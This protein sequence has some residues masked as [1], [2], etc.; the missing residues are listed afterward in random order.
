[1]LALIWGAVR[2]RRA[3]VLTVLI[4]TAPAAALAAAAPWFAEAAADRSTAA[5]VAAAPADQRILSIRQRVV[6]NGDPSAS[7][8]QFTD[9]VGPKLPLPAAAPAVGLVQSL[10][11]AGRSGQQPMPVAYRD[12][13]CAHLRLEGSCPAASLETAISRSTAQQLGLS[14]GQTL[15]L[16]DTLLAEPIKLKVVAIY[17]LAE[18]D[19][20]YW[21]NPFYRAGTGPDPV[22]TPLATFRNRRRPAPSG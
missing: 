22:F 18:P 19:G 4:L 5:D 12:D 11:Q 9:L 15:P 1:M 13:Y 10:D 7:I 16:R 3:Q 21:S 17:E 6:T 8:R 14:V 2:T 20:I